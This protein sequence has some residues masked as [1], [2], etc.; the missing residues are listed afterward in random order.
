[1]ATDQIQKVGQGL[2]TNYNEKKNTQEDAVALS[3]A[4]GVYFPKGHVKL[5]TKN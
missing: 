5:D 1:M 4:H 3:S 2:G